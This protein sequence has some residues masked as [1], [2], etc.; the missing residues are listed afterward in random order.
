MVQT[1][2]DVIQDRLEVAV[3]TFLLN[4]EFAKNFQ[5]NSGDYF[6][7]SEFWVAYS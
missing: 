3:L 6:W 1:R 7:R 5:K 2:M 4:R